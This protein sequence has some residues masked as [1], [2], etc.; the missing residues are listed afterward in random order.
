MALNFKVCP[1]CGYNTLPQNTDQ[2][3]GSVCPSCGYDESMDMKFQYT[4][5]FGDHSHGNIS[6]EWQDDLGGLPLSDGDKIPFHS[7]IILTP[8]PDSGYHFS[9]WTINGVD[10][11]EENPLIVIDK[12]TAIIC[13]FE[14]N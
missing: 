9:K 4:I 6:G 2:S 5:T 11:S 1:I 7:T 13:V 10:I 14:A 3:I 12:D 8:V